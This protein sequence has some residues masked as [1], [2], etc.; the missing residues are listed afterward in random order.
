MF[1]HRLREEL[2]V[3]VLHDLTLG[4]GFPA[5]MIAMATMDERALYHGV[6][7]TVTDDTIVFASALV[8]LT[9]RSRRRTS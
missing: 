5:E 4:S 2:G 1:N 8:F 9:S 7:V 6:E 3:E